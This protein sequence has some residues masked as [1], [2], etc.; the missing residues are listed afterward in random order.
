MEKIMPIKTTALALALSLCLAASAAA[1]GSGPDAVGD[2]LIPPDVI[3]SHQDDL[4]LSDQQKTA[5]QGDVQR[6]QVRFVQLQWRLS[7]AVEKLATLLKQPHI[8]ESKAM[9]QLDNELAIEHDVKQTQLLL[10]IAVK[11]ELTPEQQTKA[12]RLKHDAGH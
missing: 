5:I 9:A 2:A 7:S 4:G 8:D 3:M 1:Q 6:A 10:M 12:F 11:N